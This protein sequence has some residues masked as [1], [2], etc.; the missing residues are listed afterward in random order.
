MCNSSSNKRKLLLLYLSCSFETS[1]C[2]R[3]KTFFFLV[4]I[5]SL[6]SFCLQIMIEMIKGRR[7]VARVR[8]ESSQMSIKLRRTRWN[9]TALSSSSALNYVFSMAAHRIV[10]PK[11]IARGGDW[12]VLA[13][14]YHTCFSK[15][16]PERIPLGCRNPLA[17]YQAGRKLSNV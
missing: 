8:G 17:R 5:P 11:S 1:L 15:H 2:T 6:E 12:K 14:A 10:S 9:S 13:E 4:L 3:E 16:K 7:T